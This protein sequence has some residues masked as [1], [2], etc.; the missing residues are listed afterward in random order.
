MGEALSVHRS[1]SERLSGE[2]G[3]RGGAVIPRAECTCMG[4]VLA[5]KREIETDAEPHTLIVA[6]QTQKTSHLY[7]LRI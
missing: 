7:H 3:V 4:S 1:G 2:G 6:A 5:R